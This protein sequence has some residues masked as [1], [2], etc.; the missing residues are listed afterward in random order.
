MSAILYYITGHGFGHAVRS[1]LVIQALRRAAPALR[2]HVR[3]TAPEWLFHDPGATVAYSQASIDVGIIQ[4]DSLEMD[5]AATLRACRDLHDQIPTLISR[6]VEFV[7]RHG[8]ELIVGDIPPLGFEIAARA[9]IPSV[10]ITNFTWNWIYRA[11]VESYPGFLPLIEEMERFYNQATLALALPYSGVMNVFP[12]R[13]AIPWVART[14]SLNRQQARVKFALPDSATIVLLSFGGLGLKDS[15]WQRLKQLRDYYFV[16]TGDSPRR[17]GNLSV[18]PDAQHS[19][20]DLV[21]AADVIITKPGYGIVADVIA[22]HIPVLHTYRGDFPEY[23][24]LVQALNELAT[25]EFIPQNELM[26]GDVEPYIARLLAK[27]QNWP[28]VALNGAEVAA[29][30]ILALLGARSG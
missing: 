1:D 14:S 28:A 25:G 8:I 5:F 16:G 6:E 18:L 17:D 22:H 21:R 13:E 9:R 29:E 26:S 12:K 10:A 30:K 7:K 19:Y 15:P 2:V 27:N 4:R 11:Y 24:N 20:Q 23:S 3:T